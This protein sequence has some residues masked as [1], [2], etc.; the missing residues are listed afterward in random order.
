[1]DDWTI[2][3]INGIHGLKKKKVMHSM[4]VTY[5]CSKD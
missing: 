4:I 3:P 2:K 5:A 1:M